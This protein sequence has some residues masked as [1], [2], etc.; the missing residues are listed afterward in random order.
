MMADFIIV[1]A[2]LFVGY[3]ALALYFRHE[4]RKAKYYDMMEYALNH[5]PTTEAVPTGAYIQVRWERDV[6]IEQLN[7]YGV[8]FGEKADCVKVVRCKDCK[9]YGNAEGCKPICRKFEGLYGYP[10]TDDYCSYGERREDDG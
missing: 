8:S 5:I 10:N 6:A 4:C 1:L 9:H 2:I 7:S 3:G